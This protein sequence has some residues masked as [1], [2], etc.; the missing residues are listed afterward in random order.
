MNRPSFVNPT[1]LLAPMTNL[2]SQP[3]D[4]AIAPAPNQLN[5][6]V[7]ILVAVWFGL[8]VTGSLVL[9]SYASRPALRS[10]T[11]VVWP[12]ETKLNRS[13][14]R[15]NLLMFLHPKCGCSIATV[16]QL[17][18]VLSKAEA[19]VSVTGVFYCPADESVEWTKTDVWRRCSH[20]PDVTCV[21]DRGGIEAARFGAS[22]SGHLLL[23]DDSLQRRFDGGITK[24][25]GHD[26]HCFSAESLSQLL[27]GLNPDNTS[28]PVYGCP[29]H[30]DSIEHSYPR[31]AT[32]D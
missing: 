20:L 12:S 1:V 21:V 10:S 32:R 9:T 31:I 27:V 29:I 24:S 14:G 3:N 28:F 11:V 30:D 26:G 7:Y 25:R 23:F 5:A 19:N 22:A 17:A 8:A 13:P 15:K 2:R 18:I 4:L 6:W 16:R